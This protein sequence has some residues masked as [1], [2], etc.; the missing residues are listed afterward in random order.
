M[1][2]FFLKINS[3]LQVSLV[4]NW[5]IPAPVNYN[6][7]LMRYIVLLIKVL[8]TGVLK[9]LS[10]H[11]QT[12][13]KQHTRKLLNLLRSFLNKRKQQAVLNR[14]YSAKKN[15]E[16]GLPQCSILAHLLF[17]IYI[18]DLTEGLSSNVKPIFQ[19]NLLCF[20]LYM[21][22]KLLQT[23]LTQIQEE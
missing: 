7:L 2:Q 5:V 21:T 1:F 18:S 20:L 3:F 11:Y 6:L 8:V 10:Y 22:F 13:S 17:L 23:I 14:K 9:A 12:N 4:L 15:V 19:M 16:A